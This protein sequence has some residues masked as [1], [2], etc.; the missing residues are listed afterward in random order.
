MREIK[1]RAWDKSKKQWI[2]C[3][4]ISAA[5]T[6]TQPT[7]FPKG[8]TNLTG[9]VEVGQFTGLKDKNGEEIYEGDIVEF[10]GGHKTIGEEIYEFDIVKT[11]NRSIAKIVYGKFQSSH[12]AGYSMGHWHIGFFLVDKEEQQI[13][14]GCG[15]DLDLDEL[16]IIGNIY[17]NPEYLNERA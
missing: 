10:P 6:I 16:T 3:F 15:E 8:L 2:E 13:F 7:D 17:E 9:L 11:R 12:E 14:D 5:G 4:S 1:F